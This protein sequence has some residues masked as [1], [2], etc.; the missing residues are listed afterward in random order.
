[1]NALTKAAPV[2]VSVRVGIDDDLR[3]IV[4]SWAS[5]MRSVYP[6]Q[7]AFDFWP[8]VTRDIREHLERASALVAYLEDEPDEIISYLVSLRRGNSL[9]VHFAYTKDAARRQGHV[10]RLLALANPDGLQLAFTHP[11]RNENAMRA[12]VA[13]AVFDPLLWSQT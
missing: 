13:K 3:F 8:R 2:P 6:N 7:Y 5:T 9:V 1:V 11:A 4:A 10:S 12:F